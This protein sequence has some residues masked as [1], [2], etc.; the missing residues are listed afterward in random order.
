VSR[1]H[2]WIAVASAAALGIVL[3]VVLLA[4]GCGGEGR[5]GGSGET[6]EPPGVVPGE[7]ELQLPMDLY[8]PD[9]RGRLEAVPRELA[10][11]DDPT[12][13][14]RAVVAALLAGPPPG[15]GLARPLPSGVELA[16]VYLT[17]DG[18]AY[19]DLSTREGE[20]AQAALPVGSREE[21]QIVYSL[22]DTVALNIS[23][24]RRVVLLWN[25]RQ[26]E[27]FAGHL[28]TSRPLA[29]NTDLVAR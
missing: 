17:P 22:V 26:R 19:L 21:M 14:V 13:Q 1:G 18:I 3:L 25:G 8:F 6:A 29:P 27:T 10:V 16:G 4:R 15:S 23:E 28:D 2:L 9:A 20:A 12:E 5:P 11:P 24:V 7:G